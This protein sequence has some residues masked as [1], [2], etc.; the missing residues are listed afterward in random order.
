[1]SAGRWRAS[2]A[3]TVIVVTVTSVASLIAAPALAGSRPFLQSRLVVVP[4]TG[5]A[6]EVAI[7]AIHA[8]G[9]PSDGSVVF[10]VELAGPLPDVTDG[11]RLS[12]V[13]GDPFGERSRA[14]L[15]LVGNAPEGQLESF[16]GAAWEGV[17]PTV[18]DFDGASGRAT[19]VMPLDGVREDAAVRGE[20]VFDT[21]FGLLESFTPWF[22]AAA[23]LGQPDRPMVSGSYWATMAGPDGDRSPD[24]FRLPSSGP[25]VS[26][27]N[28]ALIV[29]STA[30]PPSELD[31]SPLVAALLYVRLSSDLTDALTGADFVLLDRRTGEVSL[32]RGA[33]DG[34][35]EDVSGE[36]Q[37]IGVGLPPD[38]PGA[39]ASASFDLELL[40]EALGR[41][42]APAT[43]AVSVDEVWVF[44]DGRTVTTFGVSATLGWF[45]EA[46]DATA[47]TGPPD[48]GV[49]AVTDVASSEGDDRAGLIALA[50]AGVVVVLVGLVVLG[51]RRRRP[52]GS[53]SDDALATLDAEFAAIEARVRRLENDDGTDGIR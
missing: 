42:L 1:M 14:S 9:R 12:V 16:D 36:R 6:P 50:A 47:T 3:V 21:G 4:D 31:G 33:A 34:T 46:A 30:P 39:P 48:R 26:V 19:V 27:V 2:T 5:Q 24:G 29:G 11:L 49:A 53:T 10:T 28:R 23:L 37:W 32:L 8:D 51:G 52:V 20:A 13:V 35:P 38:D 25:W 41:P 45:D 17:G 43:D 22:G 44:E 18:A 15:V 7:A 40:G